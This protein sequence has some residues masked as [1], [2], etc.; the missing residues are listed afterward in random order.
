MEVVR[1]SYGVYCEDIAKPVS[2]ML[3]FGINR[4]PMRNRI[5]DCVAELLVKGSL[6][7]RHGQIQE[8]THMAARE[9][10]RGNQE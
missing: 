4:K 1:R 5:D 8:N 6:V 2:R 7:D 9:P 10:R 3:G